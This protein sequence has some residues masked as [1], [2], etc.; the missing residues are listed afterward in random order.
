MLTLKEAM[1]VFKVSQATI[2]RWIKQDAITSK[3]IGGVKY[4]DIDKLQNARQKRHID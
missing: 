3:V 2:Y 4:Y 1:K